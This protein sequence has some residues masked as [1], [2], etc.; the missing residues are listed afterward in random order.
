[1]T[2][3]YQFTEAELLAML[4]DLYTREPATIAELCD[5]GLDRTGRLLGELRKAARERR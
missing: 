4:V 2:R 1:M 5:E 3:T